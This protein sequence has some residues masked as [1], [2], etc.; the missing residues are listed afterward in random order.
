[1][2]HPVT[3]I[4]LPGKECK[5]ENY[6]TI[7]GIYR[8]N[9]TEVFDPL[10]FFSSGQIIEPFYN[11]YGRLIDNPVAYAA[12]GLKISVHEF[13]DKAFE[14]KGKIKGSG[15]H[16][17]KKGLGYKGKNPSHKGSWSDQNVWPSPDV[18]A[19][20]ELDW[21]GA[22]WPSS[23]SHQEIEPPRTKSKIDP[24]RK[25]KGWIDPIGSKGRFGKGKGKILPDSPPNR[26]GGGSRL[27]SSSS[28]RAPAKQERTRT[29]EPIDLLD[30]ESPTFQDYHDQWH[31][32][33]SF[34]Q[35][36]ASNWLL[37]AE[38]RADAIGD[39]FPLKWPL[40]TKAGVH[41]SPDIESRA[42]FEMAHTW[43]TAADKIFWGA[44]PKSAF[45]PGCW[46]S[47]S[48]KDIEDDP[49]QVEERVISHIESKI[50][51]EQESLPQ[52]PLHP[53]PA[54]WCHLIADR[55]ANR[56][57][58]YDSDILEEAPGGVWAGDPSCGF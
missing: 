27:S 1:V 9:G 53:S 36:E 56:S 48:M 14:F 35:A 57:P 38:A 13:K 46:K 7:S 18:W 52:V 26:A 43:K 39:A 49:S 2:L 19:S 37:E 45:C 20:A 42:H 21:Q 22:S 4:C 32:I 8:A 29:P 5:T 50:W 12:K 40:P 55:T 58:V 25:G 33:K 34:T 31:R 51:T 28:N 10:R 30:I 24:K 41:G 16:P 23:H 47:I 17:G 11:K 54:T 15:K 3:W 44:F 6:D